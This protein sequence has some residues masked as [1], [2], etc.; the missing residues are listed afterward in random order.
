MST[1][2]LVC[3]NERA[4]SPGLAAR[5]L[6]YIELTKPKIAILELVTVV[7]AGC[8]ARWNAPDG[9]VLA[10]AL[11]GTALV[12]ASASALESMAG[13]RSRRLHAANGGASPARWP[14]GLW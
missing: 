2:T 3:Q 13:A 10:H 9:W 7:V 12:A 11:L 1:S 6:D 8:V 14:A 5:L 4:Q